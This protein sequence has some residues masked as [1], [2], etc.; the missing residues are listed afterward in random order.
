MAATW[1]LYKSGV[2]ALLLGIV[3]IANLFL[4]AYLQSG[5]NRVSERHIV[6]PV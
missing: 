3:P 4:A 5:L 1:W 2:V 6:V